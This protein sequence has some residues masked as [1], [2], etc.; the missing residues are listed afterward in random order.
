MPRNMWQGEDDTDYINPDNTRDMMPY[1][2][3]LSVKTNMPY[4]LQCC[5]NNGNQDVWDMACQV[6]PDQIVGTTSAFAREFRIFTHP[7]PAYVD[8]ACTDDA[9]CD[10]YIVCP[11]VRTVCAPYTQTGWNLYEGDANCPGQYISSTQ[12][13]ETKYLHGYTLE[14]NVAKL[15]DM[16]ESWIE[17]KSCAV[18]D[19]IEKDYDLIPRTNINGVLTIGDPFYEKIIMNH[20]AEGS[21]DYFDYLILLV[22][23]VFLSYPVLYYIRNRHCNVCTKKLIYSNETCWICRYFDAQPP[24]PLLLKA[25]EEKG[26]WHRDN[27][28]PKFP[29]LHA[30]F[31]PPKRPEAAPNDLNLNKELN[32]SD[33]FD[34]LNSNIDEESKV[35]GV[36]SKAG[37]GSVTTKTSVVSNTS[38]FIGSIQ[39]PTF[40]IFSKKTNNNN[41]SQLVPGDE[42][43]AYLGDNQSLDE[44]TL[45]GKDSITIAPSVDSPNKPSTSKSS[46]NWLSSKKQSTPSSKKK[47]TVK[48]KRSWKGEKIEIPPN[49]NLLKVHPAVIYEAIEHPHPPDRPLGTVPR[50]FDTS[51]GK[52][53]AIITKNKGLTRPKKKKKE[54]DSHLMPYDE[55]VKA[56]KPSEDE[57]RRLYQE[58]LEEQKAAG[59]KTGVEG[60]LG[61][62]G[63]LFK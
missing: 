33:L 39:L 62:L 52:P 30:I 34:D 27:P 9:P 59:K 29:G 37:T 41:E 46:T 24:D 11:I 55:W 25:L 8:E 40:T 45:A 16:F 36:R 12:L 5:N 22:G 47:E 32:A 18:Y 6:L 57:Q 53:K 26:L 61:G 38:S 20:H 60:L 58:K 13:D 17:V 35:S 44:S 50:E 49:P 14:L 31:P 28:P 21:Y 23:L 43:N 63:G 56:G 1:Y 19:L 54:D 48:Y 42:E 10:D 15:S 51:F 7:T 3:S 2:V 4:C